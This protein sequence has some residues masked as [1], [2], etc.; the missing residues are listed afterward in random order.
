MN[1]AARTTGSL[2]SSKTSALSVTITKKAPLCFIRSIATTVLIPTNMYAVQL[3]SALLWKMPDMTESL[4]IGDATSKV[5]VFEPRT[6][7]KKNSWIN[8]YNDKVYQGI[9]I[10][11]SIGCKN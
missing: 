9:F 4:R 6:I 7:L 3:T 11:F 10:N 1:T 8:R 2:T 5:C